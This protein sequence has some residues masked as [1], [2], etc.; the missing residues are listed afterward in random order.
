MKTKKLF[1]IILLCPFFFSC[2]D[3][4]DDGSS[5]ISYNIMIGDVSYENRIGM[6]ECTNVPRPD[7]TYIYPVPAE[8]GSGPYYFGH[9][10]LREAYRVPEDILRNQSTQA[11]IQ[12]YFDYPLIT[13]GVSVYSSIR[14]KGFLESVEYNTAYFELLKRKDAGK[15]LLERYLLYN[16]TGCKAATQMLPF[17]EI[18]MAQ[19]E[20]HSQLNTDE[21]KA[22][23]KEALRKY[24]LI[25][26]FDYESI[27][28][29]RLTSLLIGRVMISA[30]YYP[31]LKEVMANKGLS[32]YLAEKNSSFSGYDTI[33]SHANQFIK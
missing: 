24:Q 16:P 4:E 28:Y 1:W 10:E 21:K 27:Y 6:A 15:C 31:F 11:V 12:T 13:D 25:G 5:I 9:E 26:I 29:D 32:L 8:D 22:L 30:G 14:Y 3:D 20:L 19:P 18:L 7:D 17:L 23:V 33:F 2:G